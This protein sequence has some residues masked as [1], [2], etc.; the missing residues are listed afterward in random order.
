MH[1]VDPVLP[2][3]TEDDQLAALLEAQTYLHSLGITGWQDAIIGTY[4]NMTDASGA[5]VRAEAEQRLT[6][7]VVGA[8]WWDRSRGAEQVPELVERRSRLAGE[9]FRATSVKIMQD[10]IAENFTAGLTTPYLDACGHR[11]D[12]T[13]LSFVDPVA[14]A[15][16]VRELDRLGFGVHVHAIGDR[17]VREALDAFQAARRRNGVTGNRHHIAHIQVIHPEDV[18]RF[19]QLDVT[20]NM[21]PLWAVHDAQMDEFAIPFLGPERAGWQYP[22]ASLEASGARLA[23]GS[24]WPVS[25]PDPLHGI[26]VAVNRTSPGSDEPPFLGAR[27][28]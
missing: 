15:E 19:A 25:S 18:A 17:A 13:G 14:L 2:T 16:H 23:G 11:T 8:L 24:D 6:A 7:R 10:G 27:R 26:H 22:F 3:A 5:Y 1:L 28:T 9:R 21:Q 20:A 4:A 12:N